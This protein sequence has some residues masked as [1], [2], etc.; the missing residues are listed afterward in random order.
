MWVESDYYGSER[1]LGLWFTIINILCCRG[2]T[3]KE[4][5]IP[6]SGDIYRR[7]NEFFN[8]LIIGNGA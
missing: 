3:K 5:W 2:W 8:E 1:A 6:F 4:G 7:W